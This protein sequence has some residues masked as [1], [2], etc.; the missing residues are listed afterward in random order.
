MRRIL[1]VRPD[2]IGDFMI[3]TAVLDAYRKVF[4]GYALDL[5]CHP[6]VVE[7]AVAVPFIDKVYG[8]NVF[9]LSHKKYFFYVLGLLAKLNFSRYAKII[10]PV[11][12]RVAEV[13]GLLRWV[14][15]KEKIVFDGN[16]SNDPD[17]TRL[18]RNRFFTRII[19]GQPAPLPEIERNAEF[20]NALG[21]SLKPADLRTRFWFLPE[22]E[23]SALE[24]LTRFQLVANKYLVLVPGA[25]AAIR[26]W[27]TE[28]WVHLIRQVRR[29]FPELKVVFVGF[30]EDRG[31]I[32]DIIRSLKD[33]EDH[34]IVNLYGQT[35]L[36]QLAKV[37]EKARLCVG[38]ETGALH[39]AAAVGT[40]NVCIMGGGHFEKNAAQGR[41]YPCGDLM[42]NRIVYH[43]MD[44]YNCDWRCIYPEAKCIKEILPE[45]VFSEVVSVMSQRERHVGV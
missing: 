43:K 13:E 24:V 41:F 34:Q 26:F 29:Q 4:A 19:K 6:K 7:A 32:E 35:T 36:R 39:I 17:N 30:G 9:K 20:I 33:D 5:L 25:G 1:I 18:L 2:G 42:Q 12:S 10:Y 38:M 22:D 31:P 23:A 45:N 37:I 40:S 8:I 3:F 27:Q 21:G 16:S 15:S 11:Y 44:C 14:W 28:R